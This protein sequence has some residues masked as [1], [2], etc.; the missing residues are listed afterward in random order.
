MT[1][2]TSS[3][4]DLTTTGPSVLTLLTSPGSAALRIENSELPDPS[5]STR[6]ST[7]R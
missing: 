5:K 2:T 1:Q 4:T 3:Y 6:R 7:G